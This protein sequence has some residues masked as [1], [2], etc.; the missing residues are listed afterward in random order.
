[1]NPERAL[2]MDAALRLFVAAYEHNR[3]CG[4]LEYADYD[5]QEGDPQLREAYAMAVE[6]V[7]AKRSAA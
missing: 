4:G 3:E 6:L 7:G 2:K 1:M 5:P